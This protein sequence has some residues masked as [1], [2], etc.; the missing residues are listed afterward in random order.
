VP[1]ETTPTRSQPQTIHK[2]DEMRHAKGPAARKVVRGV[3]AMAFA[4]VLGVGAAACGS[5][6]GSGHNDAPTPAPATNQATNAPATTAPQ[7]G[8]AGF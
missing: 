2:E 7:T 6:G 3:A 8:G 4:A 1:N 5:N